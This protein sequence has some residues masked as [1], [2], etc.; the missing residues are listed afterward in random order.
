MELSVSIKT[1]GHSME[2]P[3]G[4]KELIERFLI[5]CEIFGEFE[6]MLGKKL[7][8]RCKR[9]GKMKLVSVDEKSRVVTF[10]L[11]PG[12]NKSC[13]EVT[14]T[15]P[16]DQEI[17]DFE[18]RIRNMEETFGEIEA[19]KD[20]EE[21][22]FKKCYEIYKALKGRL[23]SGISKRILHNGDFKELGY[24]GFP[25][26]YGSVI[27]PGVKNRY[28]V[29]DN[30]VWSWTPKFLVKKQE[31]EATLPMENSNIENI[32]KE[33]QV[34]NYRSMTEDQLIEIYVEKHDRFKELEV[35]IPSLITEKEQLASELEKIDETVKNTAQ[36]QLSEAIKPIA[37]TVNTLT[38]EEILKIVR[39]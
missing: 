3:S 4:T 35:L 36:Q 25:S 6:F 7:K 5:H 16:K 22:V 34:A 33:K 9:S 1:G 24:N 31:Y 27:N 37:R 12:D 15:V 29:F 18:Q 32:H 10:N 8:G 39:G 38:N 21:R 23:I 30:L 14:T 19:V 13:H 2:V 26:F 28:L 11:Q 17:S 20:S